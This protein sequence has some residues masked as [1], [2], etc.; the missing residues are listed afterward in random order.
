MKVYRTACPRDCLGAC[1]L[2][3]TVDESGRLIKVQGDEDHPWTRGFTCIKAKSYPEIVYS[4]KRLKKPLIKMGEVFKEASWDYALD[5]IC[6]RMKRVIGEYGNLAVLHESS[7]GSEALTKNIDRGFFNAL[8]GVTVTEGSLCW[9]AGIAAQKY[10]FG[11]LSENDLTEIENAKTLV[12]WG[13]NILS[14][15]PNAF[16][17]IKKAIEKGA[18]LILVNPFYTGLE[19]IASL[20]IRP[21]PGTDSAL[22]LGACAYLVEKNLFDGEYVNK[23]C[24]GFE[25]F[26]EILKD[27]T[28]SA[29]EEICGLPKEQIVELANYYS[30]NKPVTTLLGY[31]LQ[32]YRGGGNTIRAIDA[33]SALTG[34]IGKRGA[35]VSYGSDI[36]WNLFSHI[37]FEEEVKFKRHF[38][39]TSLARDILN[40]QDPPIKFAL[41]NRANVM[42]N[43]PNVKLM[44]EALDSIDT[45]VVIDLF[46][47]D[48]AKQADII[49]PCTTFF[50]EE[51][52]K[53]NSWSPYIYYCPKV[54]DPI[55]DGRSDEEIFLEL[56]KRLNLRPFDG[57]TKENLLEWA[58]KP[59]QSIGLSFAELKERGFVRHPFAPYVAWQE[60]KFR[61]PSG[62]FEFY[63]ERAERDGQSPLP[64]YLKPYAKEKDYPYYLI[65][66]HSKFRIHTQFQQAETIEKINPFPKV[67]IHPEEAAEKGIFEGEMVE[68][69]NEKGKIKVRAVFEENMR[70]DI[71]MVESGWELESEG[72]VN[73]IIEENITEMGNSAALYDEKADIRKVTAGDKN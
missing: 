12:L 43:T 41:I 46:M 66:M 24:Y 50:E 36:F 1:A 48:T 49:L 68:V 5:E 44:K 22:A 38:N 8:G 26:K 31:G 70:R 47:T 23:F 17:F 60:G 65:S 29:V 25:K 55:F 61:T 9:G 64:L 15:Q 28:L 69:F 58:V 56:A 6:N 63:S 54:I 18:K 21:K 19:K 11:G 62:K 10:D 2:K 57:L 59:L 72:N 34:N 7:G 42:A 33:L 16:Y 3:A 39:K 37:L 71:L 73:I 53:V 52:V 35:G 32:R 30:G 51:N 14:T 45:V 27:Y 4:E 67:F 13:R 20:I 40:S